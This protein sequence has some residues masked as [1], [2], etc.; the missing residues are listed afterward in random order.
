MLDHE[1]VGAFD[2]DVAQ[3]RMSDRGVVPWRAR[4]FFGRIL[5]WPI[6]DGTCWVSIFGDSG[7]IIEDLGNVAGLFDDTDS[8]IVP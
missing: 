1:Y 6:G 8:L 4:S 2:S 7:L 3:L 5:G